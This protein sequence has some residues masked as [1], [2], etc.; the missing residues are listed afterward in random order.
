MSVE[1]DISKLNDLREIVGQLLQ[2]AQKMS[3]INE[4]VIVGIGIA[5]PIVIVLDGLKL[6]ICYRKD[7]LLDD[8]EVARVSTMDAFDGP[9]PRRCDKYMAKVAAFLERR[10][11]Y[12]PRGA[13]TDKTPNLFDDEKVKRIKV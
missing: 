10:G 7:K 13:I 6:K 5:V 8:T 9:T 11:Q 12:Q 1:I 2:E 4:G 3:S